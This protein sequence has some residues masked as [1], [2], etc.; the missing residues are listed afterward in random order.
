MHLRDAVARRWLWGAF[1]PLAFRAILGFGLGGIM[2]GAK[3]S[4]ITYRAFLRRCGFQP[5]CEFNCELRRDL[6]YIRHP[7]RACYFYYDILGQ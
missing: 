7:E 6:K 3:C 5:I 2:S 1:S 4:S